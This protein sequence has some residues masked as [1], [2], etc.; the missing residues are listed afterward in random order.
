MALPKKPKK[1]ASQGNSANSGNAGA[2]PQGNANRSRPQGQPEVRK[3][4]RP[5][6]VSNPY[7]E[8]D[9]EVF[10]SEQH[11][12]RHDSS[13]QDNSQYYDD[14]DYEE[15]YD[16]V[17]FEDMEQPA[18]RAPRRPQR[19]SRPQ[20]S[21]GG[22]TPRR[23]PPR[24]EY[25]D[26]NS[27]YTDDYN[28]HN[29]VNNSHQQ[30]NDYDYNDY[31][32]DN[33]YEDEYSNGDNENNDYSDSN[34]GN[35]YAPDFD[36]YDG[37]D[38][39]EIEE[40][41][42]RRDAYEAYDI[43]EEEVQQAARSKRRKANEKK[44]KGRGFF[45]TSDKK[46]KK[47][48]KG[49]DVYVDEKSGKLE[50]YAKRKIKVSEFDQR[51]NRQKKATYIQWSVLALATV[52]VGMGVKNAVV[53]PATLSEEEVQ[54]I[55]MAVV[56]ETAFPQERAA[57]VAENFVQTYLAVGN[58]DVSSD[59]LSFF[60][61][62]ALSGEF[63]PENPSR[64][65]ASN[66]GNSTINGSFNQRIVVQPSV[67]ESTSIDDNTGFFTVGALVKPGAYVEEDEQG[68]VPETTG[69]DARWMFFNVN[70]YYDD[71][72]DKIYVT[73]DSPTLVP[74]KAVGGSADAPDMAPLGNGTEVE[75]SVL[76]EISTVIYGY[77]RGYANSTK[78]NFS[79]VEQYLSRSAEDKTKDG[80]GGEYELAGSAENAIVY[81]AYQ[82]D[83]P[84]EIKVHVQVSWL[85]KISLEGN[86]EEL[87][88]V[89]YRSNY[90]A[91]LV[92][93]NEG[94]WEVQN[95]DSLKFVPES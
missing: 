35:G 19:P 67:Y 36:P 52:L 2:R 5:Q 64:N 15:E 33:R 40:L 22:N 45:N 3:P 50:P 9:D 24:A 85:N 14:G 53:P 83:N 75:D 57:V 56:G 7:D 54:G 37:L 23:Q 63:D 11:M 6:P 79:E 27:G 92:K 81:E 20:V 60:Y 58:G 18:Q 25:S 94:K 69:D 28:A 66:S 82:T 10:T 88:S 70:I 84:N 91:T 46:R 30:R 16:D 41:D 95:F 59:A 47:D 55:S 71:E 12:P 78:D 76:Q 29:D 93:D 13:Y 42:R 1:P 87:A 48:K 61:T 65:N 44:N 34:V 26:D 43:P 74:D 90:V 62:G 39:E 89:Q 32:D 31:E 77:V 86:T 73:P 4:Q 8:Q 21:R 49:A 68:R 80:L 72:K 38:D 17:G 51:K